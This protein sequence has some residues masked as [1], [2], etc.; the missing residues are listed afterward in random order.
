[1]ELNPVQLME[2]QVETLYRIDGEGRL[3]GVN[4][5]DA[6]AAALFFLGRTSA[7]NIWRF[8]ADLP[9]EVQ[10]AIEALC[11]TEAVS[12]DFSRLPH[13]YEAI[14]QIL[15]AYRPVK[16]EWRG[17][18]Y[19]FPDQA[20][21]SGQGVLISEAN[22]HLLEGPFAGLR[23]WWRSY[24]PCLAIVEQGQV[25]S[26]CFSSRTSA[27]AAEAGVETAPEF[28]GRGYASAVVARWAEVVRQS[29]RRPLY[30]TS[31][32]NTASQGVARKLGLVLYGEDCSFS[33]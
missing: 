2:L 16:G 10:A 30:S 4:E 14:K 29:G 20:G 24:Q 11:K 5:E 22:L 15:N 25:V 6:P 12:P 26:I 9:G 1:M 27:Y 33:E 23:N 31:W 21:S 19:T 18:A 13:H 7:G 17:P 28:R 8:R 32:D 3:L